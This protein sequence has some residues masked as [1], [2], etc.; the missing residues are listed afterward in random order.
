MVVRSSECLILSTEG[1]LPI[2]VLLDRGPGFLRSSSSSSSS[3]L[4]LVELYSFCISAMIGKSS[5]RSRFVPTELLFKIP[6]FLGGCLPD[7]EA[8]SSVRCFE[9]PLLLLLLSA[10]FWLLGFWNLS[11]LG[12]AGSSKVNMNPVS[13]SPR[14]FEE[15]AEVLSVLGLLVP[16]ELGVLFLPFC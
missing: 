13:L 14:I 6:F 2:V 4:D 11:A 9:V 12:E 15:C 16:V 1:L 5:R 3:E 7:G 10:G 8:I